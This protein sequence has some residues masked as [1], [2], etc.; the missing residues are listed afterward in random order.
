MSLAALNVGKDGCGRL[1]D[2][3]RLCQT[4]LR[5]DSLDSVCV[6]H[7]LYVVYGEQRVRGE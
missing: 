3:L 7:T 1:K 4:V 2:C 6:S 5:G